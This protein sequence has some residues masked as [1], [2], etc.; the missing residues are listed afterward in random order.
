MAVTIACSVICGCQAADDQSSGD[1]DVPVSAPDLLTTA[2]LEPSV[3][4]DRVEFR[5]EG[6]RRLPPVDNSL[7]PP[8]P[9][10]YRP[11]ASRL[12][13][14]ASDKSK[15]V[16]AGSIGDD[17]TMIRFADAVSEPY[18]V[19]RGLFADKDRAGRAPVSL[20]LKLKNEQRAV[21]LPWTVASALPAIRFAEEKADKRQP[22]SPADSAEIFASL[23]VT[24]T[25]KK[26]TAHQIADNPPAATQLEAKIARDAARPNTGH[27]LAVRSKTSAADAGTPARAPSPENPHARLATIATQESNPPSSSLSR[28]LNVEAESSRDTTRLA[29]NAVLLDPPSNAARGGAKPANA[30]PQAKKESSRDTTRFADNAVVFEPPAN[31]PRSRAKPA[32]TAPQP[33]STLASNTTRP[34]GKLPHMAIA[35]PFSLRKRARGP[36]ELGAARTNDSARGVQITD[37]ATPITAPRSTIPD[38]RQPGRVRTALNQRDASELISATHVQSEPITLHLDNVDVRQVLALLSREHGLNILVA[39]GVKGSVTAN[40]EAVDKDEALAAVLKLCNLVATHERNLTYVYSPSELPQGNSVVQIFP[41]DYSKGADILISVEQLLSPTGKAFLSESDEADNRKVKEVIVVVDYP[42]AQNR[43][44]QFIAEIDHPP[45]QVLIE[46]HVL[47]VE[48]KNGYQHGINYERLFDLG[49][50]DFEFRV[51]GFADP[52][53]SPGVFGHLSGDDVDTLLECLKTTTDAKVL[54]SPRVM[55]L[56]EQKARIQ[57]GEQ[58][59]Y[60]VITVTEVAAVEEVKFLDVGVVLEVTPRITRDGRVLMRV[61]PEVSS[62]L[63]NPET[64][65]PEEDTTEVETN[66]FLEN[67]EAVV[68]GGLIQEKDTKNRNLI[69]WLGELRFVGKLFRQTVVERERREIIVTLVPRIVEPSGS[70]EVREIIDAERSVTPL[71]D[72]PLL[73]HPRPWEPKLPETIGLLPGHCGGRLCRQNRCNCRCHNCQHIAPVTN[74]GYQQVENLSAK[75]PTP[76]EPLPASE[77]VSRD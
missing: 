64:L 44:A 61:K 68:I 15:E 6:L 34:A 38:V 46:A 14:T 27:E 5:A 7:V 66:V 63:I 53:A 42:E 28:L 1:P 12:A 37:K 47:A 2:A 39:P 25:E 21:K 70:Q 35:D 65:L 29:D 8:I 43:I 62:G 51:T 10:P 36:Q 52:D 20:N 58:L 49:D 33:E 32:N 31:A 19:E 59:G 3:L 41:L 71:F 26:E 16:R 24:T 56:N 67:G 54:A 18:Q 74:V 45:A 50:T 73:P 11:S 13:S 60:K 76:G 4:H 23:P 30:T 48:L 22:S 75:Q 9:S 57:I 72:G 77:P 40:L 17:G 55:V 69:P